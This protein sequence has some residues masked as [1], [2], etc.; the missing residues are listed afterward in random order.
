MARYNK[1]IVAVVGCLVTFGLL[2]TD[3]AEAVGALLTSL[4]VFAVPNR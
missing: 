3:E 2:N 4:A 1:F